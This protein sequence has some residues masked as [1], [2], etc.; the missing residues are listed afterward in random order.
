MP[1]RGIYRCPARRPTPYLW[2]N[3][4]IS[5][6]LEATRALDPTLRAATYEAIFALLAATGMRVGE[7]LSMTRNDVDL[8]RGVITIRDGKFARSRLVPLH[9]S[10]TNALRSYGERRDQGYPQPVST[11]FF[12]SCAGNALSYNAVHATF[13]SLTTA[14]LSRVSWNLRWR[15]PT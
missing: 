15:S 5:S 2:S 12:I 13:V 7:V 10:T 14:R 8:D 3:A 1:P 11:S 4:Q 6:L 9:R